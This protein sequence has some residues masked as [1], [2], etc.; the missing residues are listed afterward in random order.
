MKNPVRLK[1]N[2]DFKYVNTGDPLPPECDT[3]IMI[4]E[5]HPISDDKVEI[6]SPHSPW[7]HVRGIGEDIVATELIVPE[8]HRLRPQDLGAIL[9]GGHA[10]ISVRKR[11][12]ITIL[13]TGTELVSSSVNLKPGDIIEY[14]S[15]CLRHM[16][17][18][19]EGKPE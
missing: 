3:V 11:P 9:A 14:N 10:E 13:P 7:E 8:N 2:I 5:V 15:P 6:I 4:E 18:N 16:W 1:L 17:K 12:E 19:G